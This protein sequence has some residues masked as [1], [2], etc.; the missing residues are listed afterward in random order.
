VL[1]DEIFRSRCHS[2]DIYIIC[3]GKSL[4]YYPKDFFKDKWTMGINH[5]AKRFPCNFVVAKEVPKRFGDEMLIV[6]KH[7]F[8]HSGGPLTKEGDYYFLHKDNQHDVIFIPDEGEIVVSWSTITSAMHVAAY[9]G[10]K[11]IFLC[12]NDGG[13]IEGIA[14][15]E[16][17][18]SG[19][20]VQPELTYKDWLKKIELQT[21]EVKNWLAQKYGVD[22]VS[23]NPFMSLNLEGNKFE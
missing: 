6:S 21:I 17:Y 12:G 16:G 15:F 22:I 1:K 18:P 23:I 20:I 13:S 19:K 7:M 4:D 2:G 14:N 9:L 3:S 10:F 5:V 11:N 8:G